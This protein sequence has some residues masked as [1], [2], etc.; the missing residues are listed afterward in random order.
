MNVIAGAV[1][2]GFAGWTT[3]Y[4]LVIS[5]APDILLA[6]AIASRMA[7]TAPDT[8]LCM[9]VGVAVGVVVGALIPKR[10]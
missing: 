5:Q 4:F 8:I 6:R 10:R 7:P 2:G 3:G 9:V 1:L